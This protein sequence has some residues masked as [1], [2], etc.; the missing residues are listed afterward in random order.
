MLI[1]LIVAALSLPS[2]SLSSESEF[3][4]LKID[5]ISRVSSAANKE[6]LYAELGNILQSATPP[7]SPPTLPMKPPAA[8]S[9]LL[10]NSS[11]QHVTAVIGGG[12]SG[13]TSALRLLEK[14]NSVVLVDK[15]PFF[16][17][18]SAKASS[19][20]NGALTD[21]QREFNIDDSVENFYN[22]TINS[23]N[24]VEDKYTTDLIHRMVSD[25]SL[26]VDWLSS[27]ANVDL[28][29]VGVM[30]GHSTARTHRP[31]NGL[32]G[33]AFINGLEK[34]VRSYEKKG[35]L[36]ILLNTRVVNMEASRL[37][38]CDDSDELCRQDIDGWTLT[39]EDVR[40]A[41]HLLL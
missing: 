24:R 38:S 33:A 19:G 16:G 41:R 37:R 5:I 36:R 22:D 1:L 25:S 28:P 30:G 27:R 15:S 40:Y 10:E 32:A 23:S 29:D 2:F 6:A 18:N 14:G 4:S 39:L 3:A 12:L 34:S 26:A 13:L 7:A 20:I 35:A 31:R 9:K 21:K 8:A 11:I 17:G